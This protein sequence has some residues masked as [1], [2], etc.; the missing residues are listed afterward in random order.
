M[1]CPDSPPCQNSGASGAERYHCKPLE[2]TNLPRIVVRRHWSWS[3]VASSTSLDMAAVAI[4]NL[5]LVCIDVGS[6]K[7]TN[8]VSSS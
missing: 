4:F 3:C 2:S 5:V 8:H 1:T 6:V 7:E